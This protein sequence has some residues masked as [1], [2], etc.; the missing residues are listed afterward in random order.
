MPESSEKARHICP[1][2]SR[3][4][5]LLFVFII[6]TTNYKTFNRKHN[7]HLNDEDCAFF[8]VINL[9]HWNTVFI[10]NIFDLLNTAAIFISSQRFRLHP[11]FYIL[12]SYYAADNL[13]AK[14]EDI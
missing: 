13:T 9:L 6:N 10:I 5:L 2:P 7:L 3:L 8:D 14:A 12:Q 11:D 4:I 1:K